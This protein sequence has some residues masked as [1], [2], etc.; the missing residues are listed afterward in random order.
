VVSGPG[1]RPLLDLVRS[2]AIDRSCIENRESPDLDALPVPDYAAFLE[3][4]V[5]FGGEKLLTFEGSRGCWWGQKTQCTFCGI[6][7]QCLEYREKSSA[8]VVAEIRAL[9][10]RHGRNLFATDAILSRRHL[11]EAIPELGGF[12]TGP[13]LFFE[14]KAN[15]RQAEVAALRRAN[16]RGLQPGIESLATPLLGLLRKGTDAIHNLALLKHCREHGVALA[17][18]VLCRIPGERPEHYDAQI[19]LMDRIPHLPPPE[20]V[21]PVRIDRYGQYFDHFRDH[22]WSEIRPLPIYRRLHAHLDEAALRDV[23]YHFEGV[24]GP[25]TDGYLGRLEAAVQRWNAR[26]DRGD[27]LF[28][29][30][31]QGLLRQQEGRANRISGGEALGRVVECT[32]E[33]TPVARVL[34]QARCNSA[35]L[36]Q[37]VQH[38]IL[39]VEG[40]QALNLAVRTAVSG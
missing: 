38:G 21:N 28:L 39:Y 34:E 7:G 35:L 16:V 15:L 25:T 29:D 17:W 27:G 14:S 20:R 31:K 36:T 12:D 1:E 30:P 2:D 32:H 18:N 10:E 26:C 23:A 5:E 6:N 3:A 22:G 13:R 40:G 24:G 8:R 33:V 19:D 9:W 37:M 4:A 11:A